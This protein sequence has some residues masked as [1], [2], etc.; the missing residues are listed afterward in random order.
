MLIHGFTGSPYEVK[1]LASFLEQQTNW[2]IYT[3]TLAGHGQGDSIV[4]TTYHDWISS[5][6]GA[7]KKASEENEELILIGFSMGSIIASY[8]ASKYQISKLILLSPAVFY[9]STQQFFKVMVEVTRMYFQDQLKAQSYIDRYRG[10]WKSTPFQ[11]VWNFHQLVKQLKPSFRLIDIPILIV[12]GRKDEIV[13][14]K[15]AQYIFN[16]V[17]SEE[18]ELVWLEDSKHIVCHDCEADIIFNK[19]E[20][21]LQAE[22]SV[23]EESLAVN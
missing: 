3:P 11:A 9:P 20:Q 7:L 22:D 18:K 12:Q 19:V 4:E 5:A 10:K 8:L 1:P 14:P 16:M 21:F 17:R 23:Q 13:N 15:S 2:N 6:E